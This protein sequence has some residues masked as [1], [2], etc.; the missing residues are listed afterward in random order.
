MKSLG[1]RSRFR[2]TAWTKTFGATSYSSARS[3]LSMTFC[4][5]IAKMRLSTLS[6]GMME[7]EGTICDFEFR[8]DRSGMKKRYSAR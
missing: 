3:V 1:K 2:L 6:A 4:P 7:L 8:F 5:R